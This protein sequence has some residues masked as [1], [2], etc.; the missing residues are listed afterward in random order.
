MIWKWRNDSDLIK[1]SQYSSMQ[2]KIGSA[3]ADVL[4][5]SIT[6]GITYVYLNIKNNLSKDVCRPK[7]PNDIEFDIKIQK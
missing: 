4:A 5:K 6:Q 2:T 1:Q 7:R 3:T